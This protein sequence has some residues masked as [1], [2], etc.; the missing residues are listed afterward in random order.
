MQIT[1]PFGPFE[2]MMTPM[3]HYSEIFRGMLFPSYSTRTPHR[4]EGLD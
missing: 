1:V 3:S 4:W 2:V